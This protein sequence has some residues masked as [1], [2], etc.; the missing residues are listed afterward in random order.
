MDR[1]TKI[2]EYKD[3]PLP[4]GVFQIIN[5]ANGKIFI[6][7]SVNLPAILNRSKVEL[8]MGSHRNGIVQKEW[9]QFGHENFQFNELEILEPADDPTYNPAEDLRVLEKLWIEKLTPFGD[10][11]YNKPSKTDI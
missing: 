9:K 5:K 6:G 1:K 10:K 4:M 11:G 2:R 8:K 7:S 3:T